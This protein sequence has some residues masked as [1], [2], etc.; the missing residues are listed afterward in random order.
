MTVALSQVGRRGRLD[1]TFSAQNNRTV[2]RDVYCETPYK[3]TRLLG[4]GCGIPQLILM[5]NTAG[6]FG[7][8]DLSCCIRVE[9]EARVR[10]TQQSATRIHPSVDRAPATQHHDIAVESGGLLSLHLEPVI[11]FA[12]SILRQSTRIALAP[13]ACFTYWEGFLAGRLGRGESWQFNEL[14]SETRL[15]IA[16]EVAYLDRFRL[17]PAS[18][19]NKPWSMGDNGYVGTALVHH[20][21]ARDIAASLHDALPH[22]GVDTLSESLVILRTVASNGPDFHRDRDVFCRVTESHMNC[23]ARNEVNAP[24][25]D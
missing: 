3:I 19:P 7:G 8:D 25:E 20:P 23:G 15:E 12:G 22:A 11:P 5:Q 21:R 24:P 10:I 6:V 18:T 4:E 16:G 17:L 9:S 1:L 13:S 2:L 14:A